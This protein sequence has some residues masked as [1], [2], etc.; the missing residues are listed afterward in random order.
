MAAAVLSVRAAPRLVSRPNHHEAPVVA[1]AVEICRMRYVRHFMVD[2][3]FNKSDAHTEPVTLPQ[4]SSS[5][6]C[7]NEGGLLSS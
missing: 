1:M 4:A 2:G 7:G 5:R 3:V 6:A